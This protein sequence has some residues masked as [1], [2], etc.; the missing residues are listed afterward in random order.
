VFLQVI[1][2]AGGGT[3]GHVY[4]GIAVLQALRAVLKDEVRFV[5]IGS[6]KGIE[7]KIVEGLGIE[8]RAISTGKL[9]RY[10]SWQNLTDLVRIVAGYVQAKRLLKVLKPVFVFSKGGFVSVPPV[11]AARKL[12]IP[13]YSHE[14][15]L[16]PGL[17]TRLNLGASRAVFCAYPESVAHFP[18]DVRPR[19]IVSG[20]P[21]RRE[22]FAGDPGW[23]RSAWPV[24]PG[25]KVLL[26]LGGSLGAREVNQVVADSLPLLEGN[27]F[28]VHQT[29]DEWSPLP[30]TAWYVSR[31]YFSTEMPHLYAGADLIF[32]RAGAGTLWEAAATRVPLVLLPLGAGSR[33]D[34]VRNA[35]LF[36]S[37]GAAVVLPS[38]STG[39]DLAAAVSRFADE[40]AAAPA[41]AALARFDAEGAAARIAG[42]LSR[43]H[44][45]VSRV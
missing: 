4:P 29:G 19:V 13:V 15:D 18:Q 14:S 34:Q 23:I 25:A 30:D 33:G 24:P 5:W 44:P 45:E 31:P 22:L 32:G 40:G 28:I 8:Y 20:N 26:V 10:F 7:R 9:R 38:G 3:G 41:R 42:E 11:R 17:A 6:R 16:D 21:V 1:V 43:R 39:T 27:L 2:F 35:E 36:A 37:R 12:H